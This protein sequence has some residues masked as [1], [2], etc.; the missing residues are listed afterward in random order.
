M[1]GSPEPLVLFY[2]FIFFI[3]LDNSKL[4]PLL[5]LGYEIYRTLR[6]MD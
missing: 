3:L 6:E 1:T 2:L 4:G 5:C